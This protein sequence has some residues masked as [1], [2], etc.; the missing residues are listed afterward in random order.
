MGIHGYR[1]YDTCT[2][3]IN[4]PCRCKKYSYSLPASIHL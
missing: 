1:Y 3:P 4:M 2:R